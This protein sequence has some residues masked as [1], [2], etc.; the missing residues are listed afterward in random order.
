ML[1][2]N[3]CNFLQTLFKKLILSWLTKSLIL[4]YL[5]LYS[6]TKNINFVNLKYYKII[7][8][9]SYSEKYK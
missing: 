9:T 7:T 4:F 8:V 5:L 1:K 3:A 2:E 6:L